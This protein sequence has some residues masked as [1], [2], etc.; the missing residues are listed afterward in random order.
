VVLP[1]VVLPGVVVVP[2][3]GVVAALPAAP[4]CVVVPVV[5][6]GAVAD[7]PAVTPGVPGV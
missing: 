4:A 3:C 5:V 7:D 1:G 2:V 6:P